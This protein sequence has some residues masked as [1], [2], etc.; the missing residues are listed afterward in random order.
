MLLRA[1]KRNISSSL[2]VHSLIYPHL[3]Q[4]QQ[5]S[6]DRLPSLTSSA[7]LITFSALVLERLSTAEQIT[8]AH[9][10]NFK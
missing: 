2:S 6:K 9:K 10:V 5:G 7:P 3:C 1:G 4:G 8:H